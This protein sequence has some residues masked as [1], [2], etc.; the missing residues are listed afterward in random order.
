M[1]FR[2]APLSILHAVRERIRD[3]DRDQQVFSNVRD[4]DHWIT[5]QP[6]WAQGRL[7][8]ILFGAFSFLALMLAAVGLYSVVAYGVAQRTS[9]FGV[10]MALGARS[11]DVLRDVF[12][13][14]ATSVGG[15]LLA[16]LLLSIL[17]NGVVAHW[18]EGG[19][20]NPLIILA[21]M[22]VLMSIALFACFVPA[23]RAARIEPMTALRYE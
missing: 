9:E 17:F 20:R 11:R 2:S 4:L 6:E 21:V 12:S 13:S 19:S 1:L 7:I 5:T 14:T 18:V 3:V 23:R 15:G 10:R 8:T 16:G 22:L